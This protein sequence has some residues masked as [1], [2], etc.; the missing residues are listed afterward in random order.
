MPCPSGEPGVGLGDRYEAAA[1]DE[2]EREAVDALQLC[3]LIYNVGCNLSS[4]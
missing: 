4:E 1:A 2:H 3:T